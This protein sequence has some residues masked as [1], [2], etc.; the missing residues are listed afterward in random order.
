[1]SY[2]NLTTI[3][4]LQAWL[5]SPGGGDTAEIGILIQVASELIGRFCNRNNL[6]SVLSYTENYFRGMRK[7]ADS[8][9]LTLRNFPI[10]SVTSVTMNN[11]AITALTQSTLQSG[12][13]GYFV[14]ELDGEPRILKFLYTPPSFPI[15]VVYTAGYAANAIPMPLQQ[16]CIQF[17]SEIYRSPEWLG[18]KSRSIAGE[19][20]T[21]DTAGVWGMSNRVKMMLAP[22]RDIV[23]FRGY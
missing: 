15:T 2:D 1:M 23:V 7:N 6:G 11:V 10:V 8:Y 9:D 3:S 17:A 14:P 22:Y 16:A 4:A 21:Y 19:T 5:K 18:V 20:I 12:Q 13:A